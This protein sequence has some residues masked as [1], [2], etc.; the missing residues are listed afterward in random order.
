MSS[1]TGVGGERRGGFSRR[2]LI[3][4]GAAAGG[5]VAL[6]SLRNPLA[7]SAARR[8]RHRDV[9]VIGGGLAGLS[10]ARELRKQGASVA[11]LEARGRVGG[12]T[13]NK[14]LGKGKVVEI[15]GQWVGPTQDHVLTTIDDLGLDTF[16]TYVDGKN[17]Y[18]RNGSK[19][20]YSGT[21]PPVSAPVLGD[22]AVAINTINQQAAT[23]PVDSPWDAPE[24]AK[25]DAQTFEDWKLEHMSTQEGRDL[26]DL[27]FASVFAA[28]PRDV[29]LLY[30]LYYVAG[31]A[32][33]FNLLINTT[34]GAQESRVVGG[35]QEISIEMAKR[36][37]K[38]VRL[39]TA[40]RTIRDRGKHVEVRA[41]KQT[42]VGK[43]VI[44]TLPPALN[45]TI[46]NLPALPADRM[47]LEQRMPMGSVIKCLAVYDAPFWRDMGLSGMATST[48]GPVKLTYDNSPPDGSP[49]V[50]L[51]FIEGQEA[52]NWIKKSERARQEAV[53]ACF[54]RYFGRQ[55]R[56][57][58][59]SY[60]E[61]S[62]ASDR[63]SRGCY[64]GVM[65]PGV[66]TGYE[67]AFREPIGRMHFAGTET[68]TEWPGYMDGAIQSGQRVAGEVS[69]SL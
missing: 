36:L 43:R 6:G 27:A 2:G 19:Q 48:T 17:V 29:S 54:E 66:L 21:I 41:G 64:V 47:Q 11:V 31:A 15:G 5:G 7:A 22:I 62:W 63:W 30:A 42:W 9:I 44:N 10:A 52:R 35:S 18:F 16:K 33:D 32:G 40:V 8:K 57:N 39:S 46:R 24:A 34:G 13:L 12:R 61:K 1:A 45:P 49:G 14:Q 20:L 56:V 37:G 50:L 58:L 67:D 65:P 53:I 26:I 28:E 25:W 4:A 23:V 60:M 68:A 3:G 59:R 55:A 51:G 69:G 38:A